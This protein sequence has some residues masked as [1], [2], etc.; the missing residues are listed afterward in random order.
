MLSLPNEIISYIYEFDSTYYE[1]YDKVIQE[2]KKEQD[3]YN[4]TWWKYTKLYRR[5][6]WTGYIRKSQGLMKWFK[7]YG[8]FYDFPY[9]NLNKNC[10][11]DYHPT[12][13]RGIRAFNL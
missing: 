8:V 4:D 5:N 6:I 9:Y 7:K 3:E 2:L 13:E 1:K 10:E 12:M 11:H